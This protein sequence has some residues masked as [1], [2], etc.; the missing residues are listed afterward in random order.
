MTSRLEAK[1]KSIIPSWTQ[2]VTLDDGFNLNTLRDAGFYAVSSP[3]GAPEVGDFFVEVIHGPV[4]G[5]SSARQVLINVASGAEWIRVYVKT[6][7]WSAW[8]ERGSGASVGTDLSITNR[9]TTT[10][11]VASSTGND[12]TIPIA[13]TLLGGLMTADDKVKLDGIAAGADDF[14]GTDLTKTVTGT[15]ITVES[16]TGSDVVLGAATATDAG[17][18]TAADKVILDA[19]RGPS[20]VDNEFELKDNAD[21]T[22]KAVFELSSVATGTTRTIT[23]PNA[24]GT[25][26]LT[27]NTES[28]QNKTLDNTNTLS[29]KDTLFTLQDDGDVTKILAFQLSGITTGTTRTLTV[30]NASGAIALAADFSQSIG[31]APGAVGTPSLYAAGDVNT[32][33]WFPAADTLAIS[34]GGSERVRIDS[35]GNVGIGTTSPTYKLDIYGGNARINRVADAS[36]LYIGDPTSGNWESDIQFISSNSATNWRMASNRVVAGALSFTPSTVAGGSTFTTPALTL[37][38]TSNV[39]IGTTSPDALLSVNGIASFGDGA[40]ST[41]SITN[42]GDL[43]TGIWFPAADTVAISTGGSERVRIDSAG[44][45]SIGQSGT[46]YNEVLGVYKATDSFMYNLV[47]NV[48]SGSSAYAGTVFNAYGNSWGFRLGALAANSNKFEI[49]SDAVGTPVARMS[50]DTT[51]NVG[52]GTTSPANLLDVA[53]T[54]QMDAL[55]IDATPSASAATTTH[56]LAV[57]LNGSTYYLL[58][59]NV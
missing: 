38:S 5:N 19:L 52:I 7:G 50:I 3:G 9:T 33:I 1:A 18:L 45:V 20:F 23:I 25:I 29:I 51:G 35:S 53:G 16:S 41:P 8:V 11:D 10:L 49:V 58:L 39:G 28:L 26:V 14:I 37:T 54:V 46:T 32:G 24:S 12:V 21:A 42:F 44:G 22:K 36:I 56:K 27:G 40:A 48:D 4:A 59:S 47:R 34:T 13:T 57:N 6:T 55:R 17:L 30:P 31:L 2:A 43:N 15:Q